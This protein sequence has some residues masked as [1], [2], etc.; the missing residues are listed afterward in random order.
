MVR[1]SARSSSAAAGSSGASSVGPSPSPP[2]ASLGSSSLPEGGEIGRTGG[3]AADATGRRGAGGAPPHAAR[4]RDRTGASRGRGR[5]RARG[6]GPGERLERGRRL[7]Q[8]ASRGSPSMAGGRRRGSRASGRPSGP[9]A[10]ASG[11][12]A[13]E[14]SAPARRRA[15]AEPDRRSGEARPA[16]PER[17]RPGAGAESAGAFAAGGSGS[18]GGRG[19]SAPGTG[20]VAPGAMAGGKG[21]APVVRDRPA[22]TVGSS[23]S[24][25]SAGQGAARLRGERDGAGGRRR[26]RGRRRDQLRSGEHRPPAR[27]AQRRRGSLRELEPEVVAALAHVFAVEVVLRGQRR[28]TPGDGARRPGRTGR[29]RGRADEEAGGVPH[30]V[31]GRGVPPLLRNRGRGRRLVLEEPGKRHGEEVGPGDRD[32]TE[33]LGHRLRL[34]ERVAQQLPG[35][36]AVRVQLQRLLEELPRA[37]EVAAHLQPQAGLEQLVGPRAHCL[38]PSRSRTPTKS[39]RV[40]SS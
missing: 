36:D 12:R 17:A 4:K 13:E 10:G 34:G 37:G 9:R 6:H 7:G 1:G 26:G 2:Q 3:G 29:G 27:P 21:I 11:A 32:V 14:C 40:R 15:G 24:P 28:R 5:R 22:T 20:L 38:A 19:R 16:D 8:L 30:P 25:G 35:P 31:G 33:L 18:A 39:T 23:N